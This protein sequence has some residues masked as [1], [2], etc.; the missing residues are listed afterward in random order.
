MR[1]RDLGPLQVEVDGKPQAF[2]GA[3]QHGILS[4]LAISANRRMS[5]DEIIATVWG[6]EVSVSTSVL[7]NQIW[8]LRR[9]LGL[10]RDEGTR[11]SLV[12]ETG[13]YRLIIAPDDVDSL[14]FASLADTARRQASDG[15]FGDVLVTCDDAFALWRGSPFESAPPSQTTE[16][17]AARLHEMHAQLS[18]WR[19]DALLATG[20]TQRALADLEVLTT[21]FPFRERLWAQRMTGLARDGRTEQALRTYQQ[22]RSML[23][24]ELGLEPGAEL[25]ELQRAIIAQ[26]AAVLSPPP[27]A[28]AEPRWAAQEFEPV[29]ADW[30]IVGRERELADIAATHA[31]GRAGIVLVG[32]AGVGKSRVSR[33]ALHRFRQEGSCV[34]RVQG[35]R[36]ATGIPF[37]AFAEVLPLTAGTADLLSLL[38]DVS[39]ALRTQAGTRPLVLGVDDGH[40][41]DPASA[42]LVLHLATTGGAF[43]IVTLRAGEQSPDAVTA[44]WKDAGASRLEL[45]P[46]DEN[47][48]AE[49]AEEILAGPLERS[50]RRWCF[51]VTQGNALFV[52]E[53]IQAAQA[54]DRLT[55]VD[56]LWR[57]DGRPRVPSTLDELVS[58][59]FA[60]LEGNERRLL[61]LLALGEPL[62]LSQLVDLAGVPAVETAEARGLVT[63]AGATDDSTVTLSH[64]LYGELI[65]SE[66]P[67][68]RARTRFGEL[69]A[70]VSAAQKL[71]PQDSLRLTRWQLEAGLAPQV[72][73]LLESAR[74]ASST[75]APQL[76]AR[77]ARRAKESG[78]GIDAD[79]VL[80]RALSQQRDFDTAE[81]LLSAAEPNLR[82]PEQAVVYLELQSEVLHW[83]LGR[84]AALRE[85]LDR[86]ARWWADE[87]WRRQIE[88]LKRR[89]LSFERLGALAADTDSTPIG[90]GAATPT[91]VGNLFYLGNTTAAA[92]LA[93]S[94]RPALPLR[95]LDEAIALSL[96]CRI[97]LETGE[98]W[99]DFDEWAGQT[100]DEAVRLGDAAAAGQLAYALAEMRIATGRYLDAGTLLAEAERQL[101]R[102]DPVGLLP[103][104]AAT[105]VVQMRFTGNSEGVSAALAKCRERLAGAEPLAH[106]L[107]YTARA[108]AW[109]ACDEGNRAE[110]QRRLL[111]TA[112]ELASSPVHHARLTYEASRA[113]ASAQNLAAS[114]QL[115]Q[116]RCDA[117]LVACY[118]EHVTA[119]VRDDA[120]ALL[121]VAEAFESIGA[122]R[123]AAEAA[124]HAADSA[125]RAGDSAGAR[126]ARDRQ[127]GLTPVDQGGIDPGL[128]AAQG[129]TATPHP[130][131]VPTPK[132]PGQVQGSRSAGRGAYR[133]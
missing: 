104:V 133:A 116:Q 18:E 45:V 17:T 74:I 22:V 111:E 93:R 81:A 105:R 21:E 97:T 59:S 33:E 47:G 123:Y 118:A 83:G 43:V 26:D 99:R 86:A 103:V 101:E 67:P 34:L 117:R 62:R 30:P 73:Q 110:G 127:T 58:A 64:P 112:E 25:R 80:A 92:R 54:Q 115:M 57:M 84:P 113:G 77:L 87:S 44:L 63:L 11:P 61:E 102:Q 120:A 10:S 126:R 82:T 37:G 3:R 48:T 108:E 14:R 131:A 16:A 39:R 89:V 31:A 70:A 1:I 130:R 28:F 91:D 55:R 32:S 5:A 29:T 12:N 27:S 23:L 88:P 129:L 60:D 106:Q 65:R 98:G 72:D 79:L 52:S 2:A 128:A 68:M 38:Q 46:L 49:L 66:L 114:L 90:G 24:E 36:S 109:A 96:W 85:L 121:A 75:A 20:E 53:V 100:L 56:G 107:P 125:A 35:T 41:L 15:Q 78:A 6:A 94:L 9:A 76:A 124:A 132:P 95:D 40:L 13:G 122:L 119:R 51:T 8:R 7:E 50:A 19:V 4:I 42:T 71:G 69:S